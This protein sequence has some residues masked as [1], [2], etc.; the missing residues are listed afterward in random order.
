MVLFKGVV[1]HVMTQTNP[2]SR[3]ITVTCFKY[4][5]DPFLMRISFCFR[6][7]L[8]LQNQYRRM[9]LRYEI[10]YDAPTTVTTSR[11][12]QTDKI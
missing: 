5:T 1:H 10:R 12:D 2:K 11:T 3:V 6:F 8:Y 4:P 7:C 9:K